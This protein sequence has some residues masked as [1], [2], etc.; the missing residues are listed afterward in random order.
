MFTDYYPGEPT[1]AGDGEDCLEI[2][3]R[4][5][6]DEKWNYDKTGKWNDAP[7]TDTRSYF[8]QDKRGN[9]VF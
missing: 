7:C 3:S 2:Y 6:I 8:C 4:K 1:N 9:K 5:Y